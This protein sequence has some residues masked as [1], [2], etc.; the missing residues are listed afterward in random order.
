M[1][2]LP[3]ITLLFWVMKICATTLGETAGDLLSMTL[4]VGYAA[5]SVILFAAFLASLAGQ[6]HLTT[7]HPIL[8]WTVILTTSTAGTTM[9]DFIDRTLGIGYAS[10]AMLLVGLLLTTLFFWWKT[11]KSLSVTDISTR[12][13]ELFY[14]TAILFSNTLGT[15]LGD[16]WA[17]DSGLGF[18]GGAL[19][20]GGLLALVVLAY[21]FTRISR[22]ALFWAAFV[23]T[24]PF[25][26][27]FGDLLTKPLEK[28]GLGFGTVGSSLVLLLILVGLIFW[29][30]KKHKK[31]AVLLLFPFVLA[32][33]GSLFGQNAPTADRLLLVTS[34]GIRW[35]EVFE[36]ADSALL[37]N[38]K[39]V[40]DTAF[41]RKKYWAK[42]AAE[43]RQK[44]MPFLWS[45][46]EKEGQIHGNRR[47]GSRV[48]VSNPVRI[49][50]PGYAE[51]LTGRIDPRI[52]D[53]HPWRNR[54]KNV[55]DF[56]AKTPRF[57]G[58]TAAFASWSNLYFALGGSKTDL[59]V[60]A[61]S[62]EPCIKNW[63]KD[64]PPEDRKFWSPAILRTINR[65]DTITWRLAEQFFEKEKPSI[66]YVSLMESDL[67]AHKGRY[68][69]ALDAIHRLDSLVG[70]MWQKMQSDPNYR[71][72]TALFL[73]TDHG[74]GRGGFASDW[75]LHNQLTRGS[76]QIWFAALSPDLPPRGEVA[77]NPQKIKAAQFAR[78]IAEMLGLD[79]DKKRRGK[80]ICLKDASPKK[81]LLVR[82]E[83]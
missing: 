79:F 21:L 77:E 35:Q 28:G 51:I 9:S 64:P 49:S 54:S 60:N 56:L 43:R 14:W 40:S 41:Y 12:R 16:F 22:V 10:G 63:K 66:L 45:V 1:G 81:M 80:A 83:R 7:Y 27:T 52:F 20:I 15:A 68:D 82:L 3:E 57:E 53:N 38:P 48:R 74:R 73:T 46:V 5:A 69:R 31:A 2:K 8:Y 13:G 6:L 37:F 25:G 59:V 18:A 61:G 58:K 42:T 17:D 44:L 19:L 30:L 78:T 50:Y 33:S 24:R 47:L 36:G 34:D 23:L 32:G 75:R 62:A 71:G 65:H 11:E 39:W 26:A 70:S 76:Q 29:T 55:L 4:N 72:R 67:E